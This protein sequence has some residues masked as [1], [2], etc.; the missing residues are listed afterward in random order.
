MKTTHPN[1]RHGHTKN[2]KGRATLT[3]RSWI[4]MK[5]RCYCSTAGSYKRYGALGI[6]VCERWRNSFENFLADMGE[7]PEGMTLDRVDGKGNYEPGN[8]RWATLSQQAKNR[9]P[10]NEWASR[11]IRPRGTHC[12]RGHEMTANNT[13][14]FG[15]HQSCRT[16]RK[17][18][19]TA[20]AEGWTPPKGSVTHSIVITDGVQ[21]GT[22]TVH[23]T[24]YIT[25]ISVQSARWPSIEE[26]TAE[27]W[28]IERSW[29][30]GTLP[31][32]ADGVAA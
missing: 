16:C 7:R 22:F 8:C 6:T 29:K 1:T 3:Y 28:R 18:R 11:P 2:D 19:S 20:K 23:A 24:N 17:I 14:I 9:K 4:A 25:G 30:Y 5:Q 12:R 21:S 27:M 31:T 26:A 15:K 10:R 32:S 13:L